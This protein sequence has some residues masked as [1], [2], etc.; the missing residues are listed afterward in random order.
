MTPFDLTPTPAA[1]P[2]GQSPAT[3]IA[4]AAGAAR[5]A[6]PAR[7]RRRG[8]AMMLVMVTLAVAVVMTGAALTA[9]DASPA[10]GEN[11]AKTVAAEWAAQSAAGYAVRVLEENSDW[12]RYGPGGTIANNLAMGAGAVSV[13]ATNLAGRGARPSDRELLITAR[14]TVDGT[15][16]TVQRR[17]S[18]IPAGTVNEA[19]DPMLGEFA[20]FAR[21]SL[22]LLDTA[23]IEVWPASPEADTMAPVRLGTGF[24]SAGDLT[25]ST[26]SSLK[27]AALYVDQTASTAL[28]ALP[29]TTMFVE[30]AALPLAVPAVSAT[31]PPVWTSLPTVNLLTTLARGATANPSWGPGRY[32]DVI[33][34]D[35]AVATL[36]GST[37][38]EPAR[39]SVNRLRIDTS[40]VLRISGNVELAVRS[41]LELRNLSAVELAT[42]DSKLTVFAA[43]NVEVDNS[44]LGLDRSIA[45]DA[46]RTPAPIAYRSPNE[47]RILTLDPSSGGLLSP[48]VRVSN[49]SIVLG[50]VHAPAASIIVNSASA[51]LG[52]ATAAAFELS[53]GSCLLYD[54]KLDS[55]VG[56][57][58]LD[59][60][61]YQPDPLRPDA[62]IPVN[63]LTQAIAS[64]SP[65]LGA[66]MLR[67]TIVAGVNQA[68]AATPE[69][70]AISKID[71][72]TSTIIVIPNDPLKTVPLS[73]ITAPLTGSGLDALA[74]T[75]STTSP[76]TSPTTTTTSSVT[77]PLSTLTGTLTGTL[78]STTTTTTMATTDDL[79]STLYPPLSPG[80]QSLPTP[81]RM[82]ALRRLDVPLA[83]RSLESRG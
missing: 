29:S 45:R 80:Q 50:V 54:P 79:L 37:T 31:L 34:R 22:R 4:S 61:L 26:S 57:T 53:G 55:R 33:V 12:A 81:Y 30:G 74:P 14:A 15:S 38:G 67:Q 83:A 13:A 5:R 28:K 6:T 72:A 1:R 56:F 36:S 47:V 78:T 76:T 24:A 19:I 66:G 43:G 71:P 75:G 3:R 7:P 60:P 52:R 9:G 35:G 64:F 82:K 2:T 10:L 59:G 44:A 11:A 32:G 21:Q 65:S 16:V 40:A 39:F 46:S 68:Y 41:D 20:V 18:V 17:V 25:L 70:L 63:G 77:A 58:N 69:E 51:V 49:R 42:P 73:P 8:V 27:S 48:T 62:V 23:R